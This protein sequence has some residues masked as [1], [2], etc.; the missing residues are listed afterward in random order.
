[1]SDDTVAMPAGII[2]DSKQTTKTKKTSPGYDGNFQIHGRH[3]RPKR[4]PRRNPRKAP[5]LT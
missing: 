1:M 2:S 3:R 5:H 4:G